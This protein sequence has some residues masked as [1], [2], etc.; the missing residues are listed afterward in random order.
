M[1]IPD[2]VGLRVT[3]FYKGP[4]GSP[5]LGHVYYDAISAYCFV[6]VFSRDLYA[7]THGFLLL[8]WQVQLSVTPVVAPRLLG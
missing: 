6:G 4:Y 3:L 8:C 2:T 5:H 1:P 7:M